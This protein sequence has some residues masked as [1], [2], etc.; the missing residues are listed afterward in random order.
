[1]ERRQVLLDLHR[2]DGVRGVVEVDVGD[3]A[4]RL[5]AHPHLVA[6][7]QLA[8]VLEDRVDLV[9]PAAA[10]HG[11]RGQRHGGDQRRDR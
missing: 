3:R 9:R 5:P 6:P 2:D 1:V 4:D 11:Q 8:G 7:D 10:E